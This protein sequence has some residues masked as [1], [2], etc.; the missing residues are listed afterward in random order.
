[1][2]SALQVYL[3][4]HEA[5]AQAGTALFRRVAG[6]Q[7]ERSY[8][9]ELAALSD[10]VAADLESL[11]ALMRE[12]GFRPDVLLGLGL[13]LGERVGRLKPN[14]GL[15]RRMPLT[16]LIELEALVDAVH[17]K[18]T[19]WRALSA[20]G[21]ADPDRVSELLTRAERQLERLRQLHEAASGT[22][23]A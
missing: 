10:E 4:D 3:R 19:G 17:A 14:G 23:T 18:L 9:P 2:T 1:M 16:D 22:L 5:A 15:L 6:S 21:V 12:S 20:A 13:Q 11:R 7:R 8:G